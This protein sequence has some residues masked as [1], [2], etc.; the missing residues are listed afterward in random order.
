MH[1][2]ARRLIWFCIINLPGEVGIERRGRWTWESEPSLDFKT[3]MALATA[4]AAFTSQ[5]VTRENPIVSTIF[6]TGERVQIVV[7]PVVPDETV[8]ITVRKPST[9]TMTLAD[10]EAAGLF[11]DTRIA[12]KKVSPEEL[13]LLALL[14]AGRH[15]EFFDRAVKARLNILISGAT[16]SGK[17]TLSILHRRARDRVDARGDCEA[18]HLGDD[19][20]RG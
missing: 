8:S 20:S 9:V 15:T 17:T 19:G 7:P 12:E 1:C 13:E 5:D 18:L 10:F 16:G 14:R 6:P 11:R 2:N 3:L 4:A